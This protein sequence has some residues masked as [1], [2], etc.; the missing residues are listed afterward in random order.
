MSDCLV[1]Q[2]EE[3]FKFSAQM[4]PLIFLWPLYKTGFLFW[5]KAALRSGVKVLYP[6]TRKPISTWYVVLEEHIP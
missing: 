3:S 6:L 1:K 5:G 4:S 2:A